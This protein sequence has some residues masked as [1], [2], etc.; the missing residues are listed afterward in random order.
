[1]EV[2]RIMPSRKFVPWHAAGVCMVPVAVVAASLLIGGVANSAPPEGSPQ[3]ADALA[4][5]T[6][7]TT[8]L[9]VS[10][11]SSVAQSSPVTLTA[12]VSPTTAIGRV[13]FKDGAT[14]LGGLMPVSNGI[15]SAPSTTL[16]VGSHSL[17]A[18][19]IPD[20]PAAYRT[21]TSPTVTFVVNAPAGTTATSTALITSPASMVAR[22]YPMALI[23]TVTPATAVGTVQFR[24]GTTN[25]GNP[26]TVSNGSA[27]RSA[28]TL[29]VGSHQ[30]TAV[31]TPTTPSAFN[32]SMSSEVPLTVTESGAGSQL[33]ISQQSGLSL[34]VRLAVLGDDQSAV[35]DGGPAVLDVSLPLLDGRTAVIDGRR[36]V[37][38]GRGLLDGGISVVLGLR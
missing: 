23:A 32:P 22:G 38:D 12:T 15:A 7:T 31:F 25:L 24:D 18:V 37:L 28:S 26:V 11:V 35:L 20:N 34:D 6:T 8:T 4:A 17:T 36:S 2:K 10:P 27:S 19:F 5:A 29:A 1:M 16:A 13:Q 3:A 33:I 9:T 14:N 21:S 30:L